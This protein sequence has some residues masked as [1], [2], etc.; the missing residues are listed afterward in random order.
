M[1][2]TRPQELSISEYDDDPVR[3][4]QDICLRL[5]TS[6]ART[7]AELTQALA[8]RHVADDVIEQVLRRLDQVGLIDDAAFAEA[9]VHSR[10][11]YRGLSRRAVHAELRRKGV[12]EDTAT[13]AASVVDEEAE[14]TKARQLV[15]KRLALLGDVDETT[16]IRRLV[17]L[18]ARKGYSEGM[19]FR[20]VREEL[21]QVGVESDLLTEMD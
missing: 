18:L 8:R 13:E 19:A 20:I 3:R 21:R 1:R 6:R 17:G 15:R 5:L 14:Q 10:H 2:R 9:W 11:N 16:A 7:K 12:D 4:A